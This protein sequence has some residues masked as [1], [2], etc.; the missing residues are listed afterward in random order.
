MSTEKKTWH[1]AEDKTIQC[2]IAI[3]D[4]I[5]GVIERNEVSPDHALEMA[6]KVQELAEFARKMQT[7]V[8][9]GMT[10]REKLREE[11]PE[12]ISNDYAGGCLGCP[13]K[14]WDGYPLREGAECIARTCEECWNMTYTGE[15]S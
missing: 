1:D 12:A 14:Y 2:L 10:C 7:N 13:G 15:R 8:K 9:P 3:T 6:E 4:C 11:H 5:Q